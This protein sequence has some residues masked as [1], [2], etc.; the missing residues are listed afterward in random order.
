MTNQTMIE[1]TVGER[2]I[3]IEGAAIG[4]S[5]MDADQSYVGA[6]EL[7]Q[8]YIDEGNEASWNTL[9]QKIDYT[10]VNLSVALDALEKETEFSTE[11]RVHLDAGKKLLFKPNLVFPQVIDPITHGPTSV[12]T[13]C[14][15][16]LFMA[17]L[18][19]WFRD[20]LGVSYHE[21]AIGEAA[22]AML[23]C[24]RQFSRLNLDGDEITTEAVIEGRSGTF[25]GGWGFYFTRKYLSES[26]ESGANDNPMNG[27]EESIRGEYIPPGQVS[28]KLMVY[29]LNRLSDDEAKG[30][31]VEVPGGVN[32]KEVTLHKVVIGGDP[33][34]EEDMKRYPGC[35]LV[36]VPKFKVHAI[37]LFTNVIKNLGI[38]LWP[39]QFAKKGSR[40][41][42]YS[43]PHREVPA[44][45]GGIPHEVW[46]P[47]LDKSTGLT[48]KDAS[49]Q[50]VVRKTGGINATMIDI[51]KAVSNQG[52]LMLHVV[53]GIEAINL[54]H[55]GTL[56]AE[57]VKEGMVFAGLDPVATDLLCAR[58]MF[59]NVPIKEALDAGL[60]DG[61]GGFFPQAVPVAAV[62]EGDIV[63]RS[64]YDCPIARDNC[65]AQAEQRGLGTRRYYVTGSDLATNADI[66]SIEGHLGHLENGTFQDLVTD[67]LYFDAMKIPWDLQKTA[68][69][70]LDAVDQITG[71]TYHAEFLAAFDEDGDG[72][73]SYDEFGKKGAWGALLHGS[74]LGLSKLATEELG[75]LKSGI[76]QIMMLKNSDPSLNEKGDDIFKEMMLGM[77]ILAAFNMSQL[78]ME[79]EDPFTPGLTFGKGKWPSMQMAQFF[80]VGMSI[81]GAEFP[82]KIAFPSFYS[83]ALI[84]ADITQNSGQL[85]GTNNIQQV[86]PDIVDSYMQKVGSGAIQPLDFTVYV[87]ETLALFTDSGIPNIELSSDPAKVFTARFNGGDE[88]WPNDADNAIESL[89]EAI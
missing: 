2:A 8:E 64:G 26:L 40:Q 50:Y 65:L 52:I 41:W 42:A 11:I 69:S 58:Y 29:D 72:I 39:M 32:Y 37:T 85:T 53:D 63:T 83:S 56:L 6:G 76:T 44:M 30:R 51:I 89:E 78:D 84:Y 79:M 45:K 33:A 21:M 71:S 46:V 59:S 61:A 55:T 18:M 75:Q 81:F 62:H 19:R 60:E 49:G 67:N 34:D 35:V 20:R 70:Y 12:S 86:E 23:S 10:F 57:R 28:D 7:L 74:G 54:D 9:R 66:V 16:W 48:S 36:N 17:A 73:L 1:T 15:E 87:P 47:D 25:Y 38:G 77:S 13:T 24:A 14:T 4:V 82:Q 80:R 88:I 43:V 31:E 3:D 68:F 27:Y 5:R 22:T